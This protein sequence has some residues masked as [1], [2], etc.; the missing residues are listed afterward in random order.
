MR[1]SRDPSVRELVRQVYGP[2]NRPT[3][4]QEP[5][6]SST[7]SNIFQYTVQPGYDPIA[8]DM[9]RFA[10]AR[11]AALAD[12]VALGGSTVA[13]ACAAL[14]N[15]INFAE[16]SMQRFQDFFDSIHFNPPTGFMDVLRRYVHASRAIPPVIVLTD[17][18]EVAIQPEEPLPPIEVAPPRPTTVTIPTVPPTPTVTR[19]PR[20][21]GEL[22][23][24]RLVPVETV[25]N[26][27]N[28]ASA[29]M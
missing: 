17:E 19:T 8:A 1:R 4:Y 27:D 25:F 15:S 6:D 18:G 16:T 3:S 12:L 29:Q 10:A 5:Y 24:R 9:E 2:E 7:D 20:S 21:E 26:L 23:R 28:G 14:L 13:S 11:D 22:R